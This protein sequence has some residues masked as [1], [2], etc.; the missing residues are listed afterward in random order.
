MTPYIVASLCLA[1][2]AFSVDWYRL[3]GIG[4]GTLHNPDTWYV[5]ILLYLQWWV[6]SAIAL[7]VVA[8][9]WSLMGFRPLPVFRRSGG[10]MRRVASVLV[11]IAV[12]VLAV[13][14][15][16]SV[17]WVKH[18]GTWSSPSPGGGGDAPPVILISIDSLR[19]DEL[20]GERLRDLTAIPSFMD[21]ATTYT[22]AYAQSD[23]TF[24][25]MSSLMT[26][27]SP[28]EL[29]IGIA[30]R[31][32][33]EI[34]LSDRLDDRYSTLAEE[35]QGRGYTT[36]AILMNLWLTAT[37]GLH[38]G[39]DGFINFEEENLVLYDSTYEWSLSTRIVKFISEA[40]HD[41]YATLIT[42]IAHGIKPFG[43][44]A[45]V[46]VDRAIQWMGRMPSQ[47]PYFLWMHF[48]DVHSPYDPPPSYLAQIPDTDPEHLRYLGREGTKYDPLVRFGRKEREDL[49]R[50]YTLDVRYLDS[51]LGRLFDYLRSRELYDRS[52]I[53]LTAD[54]G[55][56]FFEH[57]FQGHGQNLYGEEIRVPLVVKRPRQT[58]PSRVE[59]NVAL[60][61]LRSFILDAV[62]NP[63]TTTEL[64]VRSV[65]VSEA[66]H[67]G[68]D[69]VSFITAEDRKYIYDVDFN[70]FSLF[71]LSVDPGESRP[72]ELKTG[73]E[74]YFSDLVDDTIM[75][76]KIREKIL[77]QT[78]ENLQFGY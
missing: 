54:H 19:A 78:D 76:R 13:A 69:L 20:E 60:I 52:L 46:T 45:D 33:E 63:D 47:H 5:H 67:I 31:T 24:P 1:F 38:Q 70:M 29:D 27:M 37:Y 53:I 72:V 42:S 77:F 18:T 49:R 26:G 21:Q 51:E 35:L 40:W 32:L 68:S 6:L 50:L 75:T 44:R 4:P 59:R 57:G 64:P 22:R 3:Y 43:L 73:E 61:D 7:G 39:F 28:S 2:A 71:D 41:R 74:E 56:A 9:V 55:E 17:Q 11:R 23:W 8:A 10:R 12:V 36:Q 25:S 16:Y 66:N 15:T 30:R 62:T 34:K 65:I 48:M 14:F 58:T